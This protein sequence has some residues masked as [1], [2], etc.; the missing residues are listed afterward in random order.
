MGRFCCANAD[1]ICKLA[2]SMRG[3]VPFINQQVTCNYTC[4]MTFYNGFYN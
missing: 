3:H 2:R 4:H 1:I